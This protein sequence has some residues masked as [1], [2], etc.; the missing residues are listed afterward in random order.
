[1]TALVSAD[2]LRFAYGKRAILRGV[3]LA[4][5]RGEIVALIG[6]NGAGKT[7]LLK[8]LAGLLVPA[9]GLVRAPLP[10]ARTVAYL[11]QSEE[12]PG[13]WSVRE[14]VQLGRLPYVGLWRRPAAHDE[15]AVQRA[16]ER[17][18]ILGLAARPVGTLSGGERQRVA[19]ARA[20]AQEPL[21]LLLDEP[22]TH[23]DLRHQADLFASLRA[24]AARGVGIVVVM[25]DLGFAAQT[26]RCLL[27]A[28]G[29]VRAEGRPADVLRPSLLREVYETEVE[30]LRAEDG[31]LVIAP[32]A[33][34]S[35]RARGDT[36]PTERER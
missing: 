13:D 7:T 14:I 30:V 36:P 15:D 29:T 20:L 5:A 4:V 23:L 35:R 3:T 33:P 1:M 10:R 11:A 32:G 34:T 6:P 8:T 28:E 31:R 27:L 2:D 24:E 17:T 18:A 19:L 16:M 9:G 22:T 21:V 12:L 25:H 26:D